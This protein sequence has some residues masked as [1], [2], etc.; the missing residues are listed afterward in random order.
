MGTFKQ[1]KSHGQ[2]DI[3][4]IGIGTTIAMWTIG[5]LG[6][7]PP[8][9]LPS[10]WVFQ[11]MLTCMLCGGFAAGRYT[12]RGWW[13]G[14][15]AGV[16]S[17]TLNLMVLGGLLSSSGTAT[18]LPSV[19]LWLPGSILLGAVVGASGAAVGAQVPCAPDVAI[20]WTAI[21]AHVTA[22]ATMVLLAIGGLVTSNEAGLAVVDWPNSFGYNM[23]AYPLSRMTGGVYYEHAHRLFGSLVGLTTVALAVH[24]QRVEERQWVRGL[25][26]TALCAVVVQGILGGLRVTGRFTL[27]T[28]PAEMSPSLALAVVHGVLGQL[29][30]ATVVAIGI[31]TTRTWR[32]MPPAADR[33]RA[34]TDFS[35]NLLLLGLLVTQLV[36]GALVRHITSGL[37][38]H[39]TIGTVVVVLAVCC[40][41]RAWGFYDWEPKVFLTGR[42]LLWLTLLQLT[43]GM[44]ALATVGLRQGS[45]PP[46]PLEVALTTAHQLVG[47]ALLALNVILTLWMQKLRGNTALV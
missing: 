46:P 11:L 42:T 29:F 34:A 23:F 17:A 9:T 47:A 3:L 14:L 45:L 22:F 24:L 4:A 19:L 12:G 36:L 44:G 33:A 41:A 18:G 40:G 35:L 31:I 2:A 1:Q 6:R 10:K 20:N 43:L 25:G 39:I 15:Q 37:L 28:S 16:L 5:Y 21:L 7:M 13:G 27:S 26:W 32:Q 38:I 30:F 8:A